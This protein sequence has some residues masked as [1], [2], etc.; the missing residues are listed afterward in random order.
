V[1]E[2]PLFSPPLHS[3]PLQI[4]QLLPPFP[5][6]LQASLPLR[7]PPP[8][9]LPLFCHPPKCSFSA[10]DFSIYPFP[11]YVFFFDRLSISFAFLPFFSS[12]PSLSSLNALITLL[13]FLSTPYFFLSKKIISPYIL[14]SRSFTKS[15]LVKNSLRLFPLFILFLQRGSRS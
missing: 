13:S 5:H 3:I 9:S 1:A 15:A 7:Y 11:F 8:R 12:T 14:S 10:T 2:S 6:Y 4:H